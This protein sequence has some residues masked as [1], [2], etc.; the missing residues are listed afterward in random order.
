MVVS[1]DTFGPDAVRSTASLHVR[2]TGPYDPPVTD[3]V[4]AQQLF[5]ATGKTRLP[6]GRQSPPAHSPFHLM[7]IR[8]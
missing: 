3:T 2:N 6:P 7:R 1:G 5:G 4:A 8:E